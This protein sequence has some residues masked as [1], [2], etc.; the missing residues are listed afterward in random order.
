MASSFLLCDV[1]RAHVAV[2]TDVDGDVTR[3]IC[4]YH[5]A[6]TGYCLHRGGSLSNGPLSELLD[7]LDRG[8]LERRLRRCVTSN[9]PRRCVI[10]NNR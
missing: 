3:L 5:D 6:S 7:H 8:A 9:S 2:V 1:S 4:P 10:L